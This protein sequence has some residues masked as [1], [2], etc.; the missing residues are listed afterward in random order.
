[1]NKRF[2]SFTI[3]T[4][5]A[6]SLIA[7]VSAASVPSNFD[8]YEGDNIYS[9]GG[10]LGFGKDYYDGDSGNQFESMSDIWQSRYDSSQSAYD[11][12]WINNP[13]GALQTIGSYIYRAG[14]WFFEIILGPI[15]AEV[16]SKVPSDASAYAVIIAIWLIVFVTFFDIINTFSTFGR[17]TSFLVALGLGVIAANIGWINKV[18]L[19]VAGAF[20]SF[21]MFSVWISLLGAFFIFFAV[22]WGITGLG[23]WIMKRKAM[24]LGAKANVKT[25]KGATKLRGTLEAIEEVGEGMRGAGRGI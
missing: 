11:Q 15:S 14:K 2:L 19:W 23:P 21:G 9:D 18:F 24:M 10:F 8:R 7:S 17:G 1:M 25:M 6:L 22:N 13:T 3:L 16:R 12:L 5:F 4:L 20:I